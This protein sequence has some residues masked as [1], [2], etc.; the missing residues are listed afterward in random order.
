MDLMKRLFRLNRLPSIF[1]VR[2]SGAKNNS[3]HKHLLE[4]QPWRLTI[5]GC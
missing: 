1:G 4:Q 3:H 5:Y 2:L